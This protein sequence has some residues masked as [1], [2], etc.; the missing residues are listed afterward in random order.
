MAQH[1]PG[2]SVE[3]TLIALEAFQVAFLWI[4]DWVPLGRL[5]D[6]GAVRRADSLQRLVIVTIVQS[7]P[8]TVGLIFSAKHLGNAY[9]HWLIM[10]L[11][12]SYSLLFI[13]ELR[14][15]WVPYLLKADPERALRY[16]QMFGDTHS[17]LPARNG[18]VPN[19]THILLHLA[20]A[21]TLLILCISGL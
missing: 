6:V 18:I 8:F 15:W 4:H 20:T 9:P 12:I 17:F 14:A 3:I 21:A 1:I 10:W 16:Q 19:T 11:W 13:G 7:V 5:N 2:N